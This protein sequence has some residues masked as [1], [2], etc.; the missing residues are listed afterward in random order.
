MKYFL[1]TILF[2]LTLGS[3]L[4]S[5]K[6]IGKVQDSKTLEGLPFANVFI[7]NTT[8]G[9]VTDINGDFILSSLSDPGTYE[10]IFSFVGYESYKM[11]ITVEESQINVGIIKL[12]PS[13]IQ[14]NTVEVSSTRDKEWE[15]KLKK[16]KK[17]FLGDDQLASACTILNPWVIDFPQDKAGNKFIAK[18]SEP[19][20]IENKALGYK[21][22]FYLTNFW[23]N[24]SEY[25]IVGNAR[26]S[27]LQN[28]DAKQVANWN[29]NRSNS[30]QRSVQHL[31]KSMIEHKI[32]GE[33]YT[34]YTD[35][36]DYN[37]AI[38]RSSLFYSQVG[39]TVV[40]LDTNGLVAPDIQ[41]GF[42][43]ISLKERT[44]VHDRKVKADVRVYE[45]VFGLVS[46]IS[47]KK[48]FAV[49]NRN[50]YAKNPADVVV[51]GDMS[52]GR[53]A[54]MLPLDYK[55]EQT[56]TK[57]I[58]V[59]NKIDYSIYQEQVYLHTDKPYYYSGETIWFKGYLNYA[60]PV[61]RDSLS[62]TVYVELVD[63]ALKKVVM[64]KTLEIVNG[65]FYNQFDL[66]DMLPEKVYYLRAYTNF[67]RNYGNDNLFTRPL[68]V[69][70][71]TDKVNSTP[72]PNGILQDQ[73]ELLMITADKRVYK[74][75]EKITLTL[76]SK[77]EVDVPV[78]TNISVTVVDSAQVT[79]LVTSNTIKDDYPIRKA[80]DG[81]VKELPFTLEYGVNFSGIFLNDKKEPERASLSVVQLNSDNLGI[82]Q[83]DDEGLFMVSGFLFYDTATFS[84][85]ATRGKGEAYGNAVFIARSEAPIEFSEEEFQLE[86]INT[87]FPQRVLSKYEAA[88]DARLLKDVVIE[89]DKIEEENQPGYRVKRPY[90]KP[91]YVIT[92]KDINASYGDL[93]KTL[94]GKVPG[95][96]VRDVLNNGEQARRVVYIQRGGTNSSLLFP[97]EVIVTINDAMISGTPEEI[98]SS[99]DP[100]TVET[101]EVKSG[102]NVLYGSLGGNGI[103][104]V[105]T[106]KD[107]EKPKSSKS[108]PI[109]KVQG[110]ARSREFIAPDYE[111]PTSNNRVDQRA[112]LYWN[113]NIVTEAKTGT[114]T[115]S[116]FAADLPGKY[117]VVAEGVNQKGK[118]VQALYFIII[119]K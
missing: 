6:I 72:P 27:E 41:K 1:F 98:L 35:T 92:K 43:K 73:D 36:K 47:L 32:N 45:D 70:N 13:E 31:F 12:V 17:I 16:F 28:G 93:L 8:I 88:K 83:S 77:D 25:S 111:D 69:L 63:R 50:G 67:G 86:I 102:V 117:R 55:P 33:G 66:P 48:G 110:Y 58:K 2:I 22:N 116:F 59:A 101:I 91:D 80:E 99:I 68:P 108:L 23:H 44:E 105:Y 49:V 14:L 84:I 56:D 112:T 53:V 40:V 113:P 87:E 75:H 19:I 71:L 106:R 64:S 30:Y 39:K 4:Y 46:W 29:R 34:L 20:E 26:F 96:V 94:P 11:K 37:N 42:Y 103:V 9:T 95:L 114:A 18:A 104:S 61:W 100:A 97:K 15:K 5:Q 89:S 109:M 38:V 60:T 81:A 78:S 65:T 115:L 10:L 79:P 51:S 119:E 24:A 118:P 90:G 107:I 62:R 7:N 57:A 85:Q 21:V 76:I 3:N 74:P 54:N 82:T 52:A